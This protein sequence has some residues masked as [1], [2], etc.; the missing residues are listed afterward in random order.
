MEKTLEQLFNEVKTSETLKKELTAL[1]QGKDT[2]AM[3]EWLKKNGCGA[4]LEE[5]KEYLYEQG[6]AAQ[7]KGE[8]SA[9]ELEQVAGGSEAIIGGVTVFL[10][11]EVLAGVSYGIYALTEC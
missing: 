8:L 10:T 7:K 3:K 2:A 9:D 6:R 5:A 1:L 11:A 4:T